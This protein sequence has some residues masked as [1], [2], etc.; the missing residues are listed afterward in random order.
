LI[1][2]AFDF[3]GTIS[4]RDSLIPFL[5]YV[6]GAAAVGAAAARLAPKLAR[7]AVGRTDRDTTK[8][9]LLAALLAGY[10]VDGLIAAG[11]AYASELERR[12]RPDVVAS[13]DAH[14][15]QAHTLVMI[16]ASPTAY[17]EP[18]GAA[19]GF[20]AVLATRLEVGPDRRLTGRF[21]GRNVRGEEKVARLRGWLD[22]REPE[23]MWAYGDSEGDAEL[24][25]LAD[26]PR[27]IG[28]SH[29]E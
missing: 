11:R 25:A 15:T 26:H 9:E 22:G 12:L 16:S 23:E 17:L 28:R 18:L 13:I 24:L 14:R 29:G 4:R 5:V 6:R 1:L 3:D 2:A 8:E 27:R 21:D 7:M 19:L 10:P 20:D